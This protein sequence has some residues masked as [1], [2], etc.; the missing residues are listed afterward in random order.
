MSKNI[1]ISSALALLFALPAAAAKKEY[2]VFPRA[3]ELFFPLVADPRHIQLGASYYRQNG[4]N[5][6][7]TALGHSWG[8][9]RWYG[10]KDRWAYQ[11][12]IEAMAYSRFEL[13]GSVN[14]FETVDFFVNLPVEFRHRAFSGRF[15]LFHESSHLGDD[16]IRETGDTGAR[17][18]IDGGRV[19]AGVEP[20]R[21]LRLYGGLTALTHTIPSPKR[22]A[23]QSGVELQTGDLG[24]HAKYPTTLFLAQDLQW[25]QN[26]Q[27]N[28]NYRIIAGWS[29]GFKDVLRS[30]R[31]FLGYFEGHSP[32]GQFFTRREHYTD[33]GIR[34]DF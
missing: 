8:L 6:A 12:N 1:W 17:Y 13:G 9:V 32:Y 30:L 29:L 18:S 4:R 28:P 21:W 20:W 23:L 27:W 15:M 10:K 7:D 26:V 22:L 34:L 24:W 14:K 19:Q 16:Y 3:E 31:V 2:G 5:L 11:W 25:H 33:F